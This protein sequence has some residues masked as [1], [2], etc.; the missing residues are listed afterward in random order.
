V[1]QKCGMMKGLKRI[2]TQLCQIFLCAL[3]KGGL[4]LHTLR[5]PKYWKICEIM[6]YSIWLLYGV[7]WLQLKWVWESFHGV[8][9]VQVPFCQIYYQ[10]HVIPFVT[11]YKKMI[12][13]HRKDIEKKNVT[14]VRRMF[15]LLHFPK[16]ILPWRYMVINFLHNFCN[17]IS[18][19]CLMA[20][21][22]SGI[23]NYVEV[24]VLFVVKTLS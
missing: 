5:C 2:K 22:L 7:V 4:R 8:R 1:E 23:A 10:L 15:M 21:L 20:V 16:A 6:W 3:N 17:T 18:F 14:N 19:F 12:S 9:I 24:V 13:I 11:K